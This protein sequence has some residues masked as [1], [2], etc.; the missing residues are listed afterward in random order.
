MKPGRFF[1]LVNMQN[2][3]AEFKSDVIKQYSTKNVLQIKSIDANTLN[4]M[5]KLIENCQT[6]TVMDIIK[7]PLYG[8][9]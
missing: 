6:K 4:K 7:V 9:N 1:H 8:I 3:M 5:N 2:I